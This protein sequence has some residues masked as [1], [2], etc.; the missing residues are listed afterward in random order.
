VDGLTS[1]YPKQVFFASYGRNPTNQSQFGYL[2]TAS[3]GMLNQAPFFVDRVDSPNFK[4]P[5]GTNDLQ[6]GIYPQASLSLLLTNHT[7]GSVIRY[8]LDGSDPTETNGTNYTGVLTFTQPN[9]KSGIVVRARAFL[10]G[11][12]P[13]GVKTHSYLLKQPPLLTNAPVLMLTAQKER[14]FYKPFGVLGISGGTF[15]GTASGNIWVTDGPQAYDQVV[16]QGN[17]FEREVHMEY[18]FP[19]GY[20]PAGQEPIREDIG[21]RVSASPYQRPRMK[22]ASADTAS[23]WPPS[24]QTEKPSF[25]IVFNGDYGI[26][27]LNYP[28]LRNYDIREFQNL[29]LRAGK[30]D[31]VNPWMT[32]ELVRRIWGDMGHVGA[33]GLFCSLYVNGIYKG[34]YNFTERVREPLFQAHY[35]STKD[36]DVRYVYDWVNGDGNQFGVMMNALN[37]DLSVLSNYTNALALLDADN[38][39]EY[40]TLYI[41]CAMWDWP[42]NNFVFARE[43]SDG[44]LSKFRYTIWDAEGAFNVQSYYS[45][46]VNFDTVNE[47]NTKAVDVAQ[48]WRRLNLSPE[49]R[50][51]IADSVNKR[52]FNN[53][54]LDDRDPDG[55]GPLVS[56]FWRKFNE[57]ASEAAPLVQYNSGLLQT[58]LFLTWTAPDTGRRSYLLGNGPGRQ[59]LR[60][61][62]L[63]PLTEPPIFSQ[64]GG[65]VPPGY[66][67]TIT[68][69]IATSNQTATIYYTLDGP[70]PRIMGG[71]LNS[72]AA[73]Y[74]GFIPITNIVTVRAR[75][76]NDVTG[77]WSAIT[78][79]TFAPEASPASSNNLVVAELMYHPPDATTNEAAAGF[80]N[81]DD[82][83][84]IRLVNISDKPIDLTGLKFTAGVLFD[85]NSGPIRYIRSGGSVLVVK[86]RPA[87]L[88]RYG[89]SLDARIVGEFTGNLSNSGERLALL[90]GAQT[91]RD[92][93]YA[94]G[95]DW[96]QSAD[97]EGPSLMLRDPFSNPDHAQ[98][99][100][101]IASSIPGGLPGDTAPLLSFDAWRAF[102]WGPSSLTN[103]AVSGAAADPDGDGI[104]NY[105]EFALGLHPKRVQSNKEPLALI[106][107]IGGTN[108]LTM[109]FNVSSAAA[110]VNVRFQVSGNLSDWVEGPPATELLS[111]TP[112]IDGTV[113]Y[114]YRDTTPIQGDA[115]HFVRLRISGP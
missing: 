30:N 113:S 66:Q 98:P 11:W 47:L 63:W 83:E 40:Y 5:D 77:E 102:L 115:Y 14:A 56:S 93:S 90:S 53:G 13:S 44:P 78:E 110:G 7:P 8:T 55:A 72:A 37:Q 25:N 79:A 26:S 68:N 96:P 38:F 105:A 29:R 94:D 54:L 103:A 50:L 46:P 17:P 76:L 107:N 106:E 45:K 92:F 74:A 3:P 32:D 21:L 33:Q 16:G 81:A 64:F 108:Y 85:F 4:A 18:F 42:E 70:D 41:Y 19:A 15:V 52:M 59:I 101:W 39:A 6:G 82:F 80:A 60:D 36:W 9:D 89:N 22:L 12:L 112:N 111:T 71:A 2:T 35:H 69:N 109:R 95:G 49:F 34:V 27:K 97:G 91:I 86:N 99:T 51:R 48:I 23:P 10:A 24:D 88:I 43:R 58:N 57:V 67:L 84:F 73:V 114:Q 100:N 87:F 1:G 104:V 75:A 20:Y 28:L 61:N 62:G 31:N 65:S